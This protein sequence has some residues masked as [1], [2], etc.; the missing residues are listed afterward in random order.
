MKPGQ[1]VTCED[2]AAEGFIACGLT[3]S[4]DASGGEDTRCVDAWDW[5]VDH[6]VLYSDSDHPGWYRAFNT[7]CGICFHV[8]FL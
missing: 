2:L 7:R 4:A 8:M 3:T 6:L 5:D 1:L